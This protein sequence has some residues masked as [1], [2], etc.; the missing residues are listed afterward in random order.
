MIYI[1]YLIYFFRNS[2][3]RTSAALNNLEVSNIITS[4]GINYKYYFCFLQLLVY[5]ILV[6]LIFFLMMIFVFYLDE[7]SSSLIEVSKDYDTDYVRESLREFGRPP[8]PLVPSTKQ[9]Y[10]RQLNRL[11]HRQ[12]ELKDNDKHINDS[13]GI[14]LIVIACL[15]LIHIYSITYFLF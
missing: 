15:Y 1:Y 4:L 7:S 11:L 9:V 2:I 3:S 13:S 8:G 6:H 5:F 12:T 14:F 10:V